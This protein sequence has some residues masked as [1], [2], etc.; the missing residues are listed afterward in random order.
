MIATRYK[1]LH[2]VQ[3]L[4]EQGEAD[5]NIA[6][7][8]G[9]NALHIAVI[10]NE[11]EKLGVIQLLLAHM[12]LESINKIWVE[13]TPLDLAYDPYGNSPIEREII[14]LIRSKGGKANCW[15]ENGRCVGRGNGDLNH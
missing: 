2:I 13:E 4:I 6:T 7:D 1:Y 11:V 8:M 3:Y 12:S 14:S 5:A 10:W 15:D 9:K